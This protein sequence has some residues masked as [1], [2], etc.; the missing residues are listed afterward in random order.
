[1]MQMHKLSRAI[2]LLQAASIFRRS[3]TMT[4]IQHERKTGHQF[5]KNVSDVD[6][7]KKFQI[8]LQRVKVKSIKHLLT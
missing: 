7:I 4:S 8:L 6:F 1:M 5:Y 3:Y 2:F